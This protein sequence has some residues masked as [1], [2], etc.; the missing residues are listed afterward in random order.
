MVQFMQKVQDFNLHI[1]ELNLLK[2]SEL[3]PVISFKELCTLY[4]SKNLGKA[5][6]SLMNELLNFQ[7]LRRTATKEDAISFMLEHKAE[8]L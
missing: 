7:M 6:S 8:F 4:E 1:A 3:E 5:T 2:V